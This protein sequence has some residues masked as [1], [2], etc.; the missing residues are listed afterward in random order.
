MQSYFTLGFVISFLGT[1]YRLAIPLIFA[2]LGGY[3]SEKSGTIQIALEGLCLLA[4]FAAGSVASLTHSGAM[5]L[6]AALIVGI[7]FAAIQAFFSVNKKASQMIV[8]L[9]LNFL[10]L[11]LTPVL[12]KS[13]FGFSGGT[14]QLGLPESLPKILNISVLEW[15]AP[16]AVVLVY[17]IHTR[18][19][20]GQWVRFA[21]EHPD[22]LESQ[23]VAVKKIRWLALLAC[24]FFCG[25]SGAYL[26]IDHGSAFSRNMTAG[27]GFMALAALIVGRWTPHG[28]VAACLLF[29]ILDATQILLQGSGLPVQWIQTLPYVATITILLVRAMTAARRL[30]TPRAL[31]QPYSS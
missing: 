19:I 24:G 30:G 29:G 12:C 13:I 1:S 20:F 31:G 17:L 2:S 21:G 26:A 25:L 4:A 11:G 5:G 14:P 27:R 23:G 16:V 28:A 10:A 6:G 7:F 8:G 3:F 22:A 15:L 9:A 18:H